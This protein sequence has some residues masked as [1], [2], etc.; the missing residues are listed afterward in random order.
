MSHDQYLSVRATSPCRVEENTLPTGNAYIHIAPLTTADWPS[1]RAI[2][3]EGIATGQATFEA[4]APD[5]PAWDAAHRPDCRLV[6]RQN[7]S[8][9]G[10]AALAPVSGRPVYAGVA[11]VSVYVAAS[12]R[13]QGIGRVLLTSLMEAS[14]AAGIWTLQASVFPDNEASIAL[15]LACGFRIVGR[16]ERVGQQHGIWRDTLLLERR[17]DRVGVAVM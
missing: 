9:A 16:R 13:G 17:S 1:V 7:G 10:W 5:W 2:Y 15:H 14:E 3:E 11:E 8:I 4:A 12:A 6:A